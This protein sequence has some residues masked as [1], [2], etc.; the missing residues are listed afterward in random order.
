MNQRCW[1]EPTAQPRCRRQSHLTTSPQYH[2]P[3]GISPVLPVIWPHSD[4]H[5]MAKH[6]SLRI[7]S[8]NLA[9]LHGL[10]PADMDRRLLCRAI[11]HT[12]QPTVLWPPTKSLPPGHHSS[13]IY[14]LKI[15]QP[16]SSHNVVVLRTL[17]LH[18]TQIPATTLYPHH[19]QALL[20]HRSTHRHLASLQSTL[21]CYLRRVHQYRSM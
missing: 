20:L 19:L 14:L 16:L 1:A 21:R 7:N 17:V 5:R 10:G 4:L 2:Q 11:L 9:N 3:R 15:Q 18:T 12:H 13:L 8:I 6:L